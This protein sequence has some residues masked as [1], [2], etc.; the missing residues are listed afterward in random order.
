MMCNKCG[1][2]EAIDAVMQ[3]R[4]GACLIA[5]EVIYFYKQVLYHRWGYSSESNSGCV[6]GC[7]SGIPTHNSV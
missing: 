4:C 7:V 5:W 2:K 3:G 1:E 6:V